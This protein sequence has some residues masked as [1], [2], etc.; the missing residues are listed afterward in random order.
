MQRTCKI[1][2]MIKNENFNFHKEFTKSWKQKLRYDIYYKWN[3]YK[4]K[5]HK[6]MF[7]IKVSSSCDNL[8]KGMSLR[9]STSIL[10]VNKI[11]YGSI[12]IL[13]VNKI[14]YGWLIEPGF[15]VKNQSSNLLI[16]YLELFSCINTYICWRAVKSQH[17]K[18]FQATM[19]T[20]FEKFKQICIECFL[21]LRKVYSSDSIQ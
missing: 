11:C 20:D 9:F 21:S 15:I 19:E 14:W 13:E 2:N 7:P 10:E 1:G 18:C 8:F 12:C 5:K 17:T 6:S 4:N 16:N 3:A